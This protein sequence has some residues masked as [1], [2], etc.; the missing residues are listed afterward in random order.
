ML[1]LFCV[2][3]SAQKSSH[4]SLAWH[5]FQ[6]MSWSTTT[7]RFPTASSVISPER[8]RPPRFP[9]QSVWEVHQ[10]RRNLKAA[11]PCFFLLLTQSMLMS[12]RLLTQPSWSTIYKTPTSNTFQITSQH[13]PSILST[14]PPIQQFSSWFT[15]HIPT[16]SFAHSP[17]P[18]P[19]PTSNS[20]LSSY[21]TWHSP[22]LHTNYTSSTP[23]TPTTATSTWTS[24]LPAAMMAIQPA[25]QDAHYWLL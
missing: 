12:R 4:L 24:P 3:P 9:L 20:S 6:L 7:R 15:A 19:L 1:L 18:S 23:S 16:A 21:C 13:H 22:L 17:S 10:E 25:T 11:I 8:N 14:Y 5:P 2:L